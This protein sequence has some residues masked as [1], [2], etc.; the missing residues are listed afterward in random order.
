MRVSER[1]ESTQLQISY[2]KTPK[3]LFELTVKGIIRNWPAI[4]PP[5]TFF[6]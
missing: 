5:T 3:D 2:S 4:A 1:N 6:L